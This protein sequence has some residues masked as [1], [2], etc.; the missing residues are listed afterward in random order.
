[1]KSK[2]YTPK[3]LTISSVDTLILFLLNLLS[4]LMIFV[5]HRSNLLSGTVYWFYNKPTQ[6]YKYKNI[7]QYIY[8]YN[9]ISPGFRSK[10]R[11]YSFQLSLFCQH[12]TIAS[13]INDTPKSVYLPISKLHSILAVANLLPHNN[14]S[15][16][17]YSGKISL[18]SAAVFLTFRHLWGYHL[19]C[20]WW[21]KIIFY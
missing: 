5:I 15:Q 14:I 8:I 17:C 11:S 21:Y 16:I 4:M 18:Q 6:S 19:F 3:P 7:V 10:S 9:I 2:R 12:C 1:M 20:W 13:K